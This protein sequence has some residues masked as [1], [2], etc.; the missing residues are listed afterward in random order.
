MNALIYIADDDQNIRMIMKTFLENEGFF[1]KT[2]ENGSS[3]KKAFEEKKPDLIILDVMMPG[4]D[5]LSLCNAFRKSSSVPIII[6]SAKDSPMDRVTGITL[7]SDDYI[8]KPF[9]PLELVVRVKALLR[10]CAL[11]VGES[12]TF[13]SEVFECGNM[14]IFQKEHR[15]Q[16]GDGDLF[17]TPLE[18]DFLLYLIRQKSAAVSKKELL[19]YV[20]HDHEN[21]M[22]QRMPDDLVKRLRKK[23]SEHEATVKIETIWGY[24][25]RLTE[26]IQQE[27]LR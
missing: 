15:V 25:Y 26:K 19:E 21:S 7:G 4:E 14:K 2:F 10:R 11:T 3:I 24:G 20:W 17:I 5:G 23:L 9:L 8:T 1:V 16:I 12:I 6:V 27:A 22:N 18:F 13:E